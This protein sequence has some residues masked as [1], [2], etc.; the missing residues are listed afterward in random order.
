MEANRRLHQF[1]RAR[2]EALT[3]PDVGLA[4][5]AEGRRVR[6][7]RR[8]EV[9][10][11]AGVSVDYYTRL[12]QGRARNV[13]DQVLDSV[14]NALRLEPL[15]RSHLHTLA[16]PAKENAA[17]PNPRRV[18]PSVQLALDGMVCLPACVRDMRMNVLGANIMWRNLFRD[19]SNITPI[20]NIARWT[21]L[22]PRAQEVYPE[23]ERVA[24][25]IV[26]TLQRSAAKFPTD[27][28]LVQLVGELNIG[29]PEFSRWWSD[30]RVYQRS[31]GVKRIRNTVVG[32]IALN[33]DAFSAV[34]GEDEQVLVIYTAPVGSPAD[35]QLR[36]L[37]SWDAE[38]TAEPADTPATVTQ[39][40]QSAPFIESTNHPA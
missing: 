20:Q 39:G 16:H 31:T 4:W 33:Y 35:E 8:D 23:W 11:L 34:A 13:S 15:E 3:P 2:R 1:L 10:R 22:D 28:D 30:R 40:I 26:D 14:A 17:P 9:A 36:L 18:R 25:E 27:P 29:S 21:F 5:N 24:R 12:E 19:L 38:A 7:L 6:G 37:A 32:E